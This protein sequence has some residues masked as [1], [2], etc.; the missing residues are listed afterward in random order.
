MGEIIFTYKG[1]QHSGYIV[2]STNLKPH[3]HWFYF[4]DELLINTVDECIG[5]K[6]SNNELKPTMPFSAP[7]DLVETIKNLIEQ[8][9]RSA[10]K[11]AQ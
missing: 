1:R 6:E 3:Y 10:S 4:H 8:Q 2:S 5:F 7:N 9:L 11:Q